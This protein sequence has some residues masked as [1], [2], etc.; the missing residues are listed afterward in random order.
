M[1]VAKVRSRRDGSAVPLDEADKKLLNLMQGSFALTERPFAHVAG[2]AGISEDEVMERV[3]YLLDKRIIR[4]LTPIFDTR[5]LGYSS[6]LVAAKVDPEF[7][8]RA[9]QFINPHPGVTHNY[10]RNHEF[11]LWFTLAVEPDTRLGLDG[12]LDV[13]AAKTGAES[14][15][16]LP[17]LKLFKIRMALEMG[18]GTEPL[19]ARG[20]A[21]EPMELDPIELNDL[22]VAVIKA[23]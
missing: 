17:T 16:Q 11:N 22:D 21:V 20:G 2:L 3:Q 7:P 15:R 19:G 23:T 4:E 8:H 5:A 6:M 12:T 10:L 13:I 18:R 14:I 9:A 1:A